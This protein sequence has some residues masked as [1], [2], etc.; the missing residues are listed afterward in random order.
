[1]DRVPG[2]SKFTYRL[3]Q[4]AFYGGRRALRVV[5]RPGRFGRV[6]APVNAAVERISRVQPPV[7][8]NLAAWSGA[9]DI[10]VVMLSP[11][12][13]IERRPPTALNGNAHVDVTRHGPTTINERFLVCLPNARVWGPNGLVVLPDGSFAAQAIYE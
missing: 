11:A 1:M 2:R 6:L 9:H 10:T 5:L 13:A 12:R 8:E 3:K 7:T 4:L